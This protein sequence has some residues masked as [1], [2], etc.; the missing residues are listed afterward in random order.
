MSASAPNPGSAPE[1]IANAEAE[2]DAFRRDEASLRE[3]VARI[4]VGQREALDTLVAAFLAG[5]HALLVGVPGTG[6]TMLVHA[7]ARAAGL[8]FRRVQFT[9]DLLPADILGGE[10]AWIDG[11]R[12]PTQGRLLLPPST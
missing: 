4:L 10:T 8:G 12:R 7:L 2:A 11:Q 3:A 1:A 6:K 5:G 9:P